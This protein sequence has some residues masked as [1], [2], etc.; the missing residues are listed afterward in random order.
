M[1]DP[2]TSLRKHIFPDVKMQSDCPESL[3]VPLVIYFLEGLNTA[4]VTA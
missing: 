3:F 1:H 4:C 2:F